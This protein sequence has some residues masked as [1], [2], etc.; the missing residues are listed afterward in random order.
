MWASW[1]I[2]LFWKTFGVFPVKFGD[3][4]TT[5]AVLSTAVLSMV[6]VYTFLS[7]PW[8]VCRVGMECASE[9]V[10]VLK[11]I[12]PSVVNVAGTVSRISLLHSVRRRFGLYEQTL[13]TYE[14]YAPTAAAEIRGYGRFAAAAVALCVAL[15]V[16][17]NAIRVYVLAT[18]HEVDGHVIGLYVLI[19]V[20][21]LCMCCSETQFAEQCYALYRKFRDING[22]IARLDPA[23][24]SADPDADTDTNADVDAEA[25]CSMAYVVETLRIRHWLVRQAVCRLNDLF[26]IHLGL[27]VCVLCVMLFFD[28]YYEAFHVMGS[29]TLSTLV[30]YFWLMQCAVRYIGIILLAHFTAKQV[31]V[32]LL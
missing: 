26:G 30:M 12:Y 5:S 25:S 8:I 4:G 13:E 9:S 15:I 32:N 27:S 29:F 22:E 17:V 10:R 28:I 7:I 6:C 18:L 2:T 11:E 14:L 24:L 21:N 23:A 3:R 16:P 1:P 20:Q 31:R 19:Y